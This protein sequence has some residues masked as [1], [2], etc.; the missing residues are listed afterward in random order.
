MHR[1]AGLNN[2]RL[3]QAFIDY[4]ASRGIA[5][6]LAPEPE[7]MF[8]IWLD[9]PQHL[10]EV[11]AELNQFLANPHDAKYQAASW[12]VAETRT[13]KFHCSRTWRGR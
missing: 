11:Q 13:A 10:V 1:L 5:L 4:M 7:G 2:P 12:Q 3:A 8:A 9:D 6:T